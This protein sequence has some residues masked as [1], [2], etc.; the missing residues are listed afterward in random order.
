[1]GVL[2]NMKD[3]ADLVQKLGDIELYRKIL[4]LEIEVREVNRDKMRAEDRVQEL[5]KTL[6]LKGELKFKDPYWWLE[7]DPTPYCPACWESKQIAAH[8]V[9]MKEIGRYDKQQCASCKHV[10]ND[11]VR[12]RS[13][14]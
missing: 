11:G 3:V 7:G 13:G 1:M 12:A 5:E 14:V 4:A 8:V 9:T 10:Y 6:K 2:D